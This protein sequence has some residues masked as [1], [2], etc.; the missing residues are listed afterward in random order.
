MIMKFV[1]LVLTFL[2]ICH[3]PFEGMKCK[4]NEQINCLSSHVIWLMKE[5]IDR[6][7]QNFELEQQIE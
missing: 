3:S 4:F 2:G 7:L 5:D 6:L 1:I